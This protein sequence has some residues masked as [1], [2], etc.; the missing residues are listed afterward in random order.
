[1]V[2]VGE[3]LSVMQRAADAIIDLDRVIREE[4]KCNL[5]EEKATITATDPTLAGAIYQA[6]GGP[7]AWGKEA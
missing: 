6:T 3:R 7:K 2:V 1:M 5:H 4:I